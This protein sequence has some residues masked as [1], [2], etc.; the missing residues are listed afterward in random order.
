[1]VPTSGT[2]R[3]ESARR[4]QGLST[5]CWRGGAHAAWQSALAL[6]TRHASNSSGQPRAPH[7]DGQDAQQ[8]E[9]HPKL[10][11]APQL[12]AL[13]PRVAQREGR[14]R[15]HHHQHALVRGGVVHVCVGVRVALVVDA[16]GTGAGGRAFREAALAAHPRRGAPS[17]SRPVP[18]ARQPAGRTTPT[19]PGPTLVFGWNSVLEPANSRCVLAADAPA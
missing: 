16:G 15:Q 8:H 2:L 3:V 12:R 6:F 11:V 18:L 1:M 5:R 13:E 7:G 17:S 9:E 19:P 14:Q 10:G 4:R